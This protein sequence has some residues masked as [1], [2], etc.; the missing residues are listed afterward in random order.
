MLSYTR[1]LAPFAG[2][3]TARMADPGTMAAPGFLYFRWTRPRSLQLHATIDESAIGS[4]RKGMKTHPNRWRCSSDLGHCCGDCSCRRP[5]QPQLSGQDRLAYYESITRRHVWNGGVCQRHTAGDTHSA[6]RRCNARFTCIGIYSRRPGGCTA[7][8]PH[9]R[10][11]SR[12]SHRSSVGHLL[13]RK[14]R[15]RT[16]RPRPRRQAIEVQP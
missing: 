9:V 8:N 12:E 5:G 1:L 6:F 11:D 14:T 10:R 16:L 7:A 13:R 2:V 4:I 15:E 3:V